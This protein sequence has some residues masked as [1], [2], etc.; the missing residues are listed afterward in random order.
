[1]KNNAQQNGFTILEL[2]I[3]VTISMF[4]L[5]ILSDFFISMITNKMSTEVRANNEKEITL[6]LA[7]I[8]NSLKWARYVPAETLGDTTI[9]QPLLTSHAF[10]DLGE[11]FPS[12]NVNGCN[13]SKGEA[14]YIPDDGSSLCIRNYLPT[15][16]NSSIYN[17]DERG[18]PDW[19]AKSSDASIQGIFSCSGVSYFS[20][21]H[22]SYE[23]Y[24]SVVTKISAEDIN[25]SGNSQLTCY[26]APITGAVQT[27]GSEAKYIADSK[28][29]IDSLHFSLV[30]NA[31]TVSL[32]VSSGN[33]ML[34]ENC[35]YLDPED[36]SKTLATN[37]RKLCTSITKTFGLMK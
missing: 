24:T 9:S 19:T 16:S 6:I 3:S 36:V 33:E 4:L 32:V 17:D 27:V 13:F 28:V 29:A 1:M 23:K 10:G 22:N 25:N 34:P 8:H 11:I 30:N 37:N 18:K 5:L 14:I 2:M 35:T 26:S 21:I 31:L 20:S 12:L 15:P 7:K